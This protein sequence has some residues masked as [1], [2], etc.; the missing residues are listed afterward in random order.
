MTLHLSNRRQ[1]ILEE[2]GISLFLKRPTPST[3]LQPSL[4]TPAH[5]EGSRARPIPP[6]AA[7]PL[8]HAPSP[9][10]GSIS[11]LRPV[12][13]PSDPIRVEPSPLENVSLTP[14]NRSD[15]LERMSTLSHVPQM[16]WPM[17]EH[18]L[19]S[20]QACELGLNTPKRRPPTPIHLNP[21][22]GENTPSRVEWLI[23]ADSP[24]RALDG[25]ILTFTEEGHSL[26]SGI[27]KHLGFSSGPHDPQSSA[28]LK[29]HI[30]HSLKCLSSSSQA[31][32]KLCSQTCLVHL[33]QEIKLL[34][35]KLILVMGQAAAQAL[36]SDTPLMNQPLGKL[37]SQV[38]TFENTPTVITYTPEQMMRSG[39]IKANAWRDLCWAHSLCS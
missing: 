2:M 7:K 24:K 17:L 39:E 16:T 38:H 25:S 9:N 3:T 30:T 33:R 11:G 1:A 21:E 32:S 13:Q 15:E 12:P 26:L 20:C 23:V 8:A 36:L 28:L 18:H 4:R 27:L 10:A 31:P 37:R 29:H 22:E 14:A 19:Q 35:P 5:G 34:R 6:Q